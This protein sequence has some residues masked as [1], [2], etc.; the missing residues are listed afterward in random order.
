MAKKIKKWVDNE[1]LPALVKYGTYTMQPSKLTIKFFYD[2]A[3][4]SNYDKKAVIYIAYVGKYK[5]EYIFK[6][7]LSRNM[8]RREYKE[9]R[10]Q[11]EKFQIVYIGE[12]DNCEEIE[13]LFQNELKI[14]YL[15]RELMIKGKHQTELFTITTKYTYTYFIDLMQQLISDHKL[16]AIKEADTKITTLTNVVDTYKQSE[17]LRALELQYRLSENFKLELQ[18]DLR[19]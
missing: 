12:T 3:T 16:P 6:F 18:R 8:F 19:I 5:G 10:R 9:H 14:R 1:V 2:D 4:F 15:F 13:S 11:F 17:E 7:G